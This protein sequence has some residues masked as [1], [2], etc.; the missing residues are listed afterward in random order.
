MKIVNLFTQIAKLVMD[1]N[2]YA[3]YVGVKV[4]K[5]CLISTKHFPSE[6]YLIEIGD[7]VRYFGWRC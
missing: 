4:G 1:G 7:Y 5:N 6:P 3:K 2:Q